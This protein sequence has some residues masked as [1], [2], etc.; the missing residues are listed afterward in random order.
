MQFN[1]CHIVTGSQSLRK[2]LTQKAVRE[3]RMEICL[4]LKAKFA[5]QKILISLQRIYLKL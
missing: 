4:K 1:F 3:Y 5:N 2:M